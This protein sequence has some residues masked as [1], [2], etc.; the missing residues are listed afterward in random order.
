MKRSQINSLIDDAITLLHQHEIRLPPFAYW[1][2]DDWTRK[3]PECDEIRIC[4]LGWDITDF[5]SRDFENVGLVVFTVRN[6]HH[7]VAPFNR[8]P[9]AEKI[10]VVREKQHT[11]MHHHIKKTEDIICKAGGTFMCQVY[12]RR[13]DGG[14]ADTD[15][16]VSLDGVVHHVPAG[17]VFAMRTGASITLTP[18]LYHDFWAEG[19]TAVLGEVSSLNDDDTDNVFL[20]AGG[21]FPE[22]EED[23]PARYKLCTEYT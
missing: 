6:G 7:R 22:I 5:G 4:K 10:L 16:T 21:R 20:S 23:V 14:L 8:K 3:G 11:P 9:Y 12:N 17:H 19:G 2:V 15:V 1:S 13:P 18:Y